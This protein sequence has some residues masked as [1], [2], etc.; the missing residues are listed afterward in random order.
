ME[1][2]GEV[3][4]I[5]YKGRKIQVTEIYY[6]NTVKYRL[7]WPDALQTTLMMGPAGRWMMTPGGATDQAAEIGSLIEKHTA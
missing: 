7:D 4:E 5:I 2:K 6:A 1:Q 3:F